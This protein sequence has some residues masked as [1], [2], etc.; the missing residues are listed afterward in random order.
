[1]LNK[2]IQTIY[3]FCYYLMEGVIVWHILLFNR[4]DQENERLAAA[5]QAQSLTILQMPRML[6]R[7]YLKNSILH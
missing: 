1:M 2:S 6:I 7:E 5:V 4:I 3:P